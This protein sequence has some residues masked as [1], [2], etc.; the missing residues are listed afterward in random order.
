MYISQL[1]VMTFLKKTPKHQTQTRKN[2]MPSLT[3]QA[4]QS[5]LKYMAKELKKQ[6]FVKLLI[7]F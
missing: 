6:A 2:L 4:T 7:F 3:I 5:P 1:T